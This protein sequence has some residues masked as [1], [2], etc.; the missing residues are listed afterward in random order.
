MKVYAICANDAV[1]GIVAEDADVQAELEKMA[2]NDFE[3]DKWYWRDGYLSN[4]HR[5]VPLE[6]VSAYYDFYRSRMYWHTHGP[7]EVITTEKT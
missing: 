6:T 7:Y 5:R 1:M 4:T 2:R 3:K